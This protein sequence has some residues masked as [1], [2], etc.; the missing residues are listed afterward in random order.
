MVLDQ[1]KLWDVFALRRI[2]VGKAACGN[3]LE[4]RQNVAG[5]SFGESRVNG[6]IG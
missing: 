5:D 4:I 1:R 2:R 6:P 3:D